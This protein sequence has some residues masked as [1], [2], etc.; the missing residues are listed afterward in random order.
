MGIST[1]NRNLAKDTIKSI[2]LNELIISA[3]HVL[4]LPKHQ[5]MTRTNDDL[6]NGHIYASHDLN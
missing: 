5:A 2:S 1:K 6:E 4:A 3:V